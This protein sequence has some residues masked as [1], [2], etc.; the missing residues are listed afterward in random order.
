MKLQFEWGF[1]EGVDDSVNTWRRFD[2][3][4]QKS[5]YIP[6]STQ[7]NRFDC[8]LA[9][10]DTPI[11][12]AAAPLTSSFWSSSPLAPSFIECK[13]HR[14]ATLSHNPLALSTDGVYHV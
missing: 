7:T 4:S 1:G 5:N 6:H 2:E 9:L 13:H 10:F 14:N 12:I 3:I 11:A 8:S